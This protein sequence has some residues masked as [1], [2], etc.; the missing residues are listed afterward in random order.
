M[1][2]RRTPRRRIFKA[3]TIEF[4]DSAFLCTV[5][6]RSDTGA[7]L[8]FPSPIGI[9]EHFVLV[10]DGSRFRCRVVWRKENG[11]GIVFGPT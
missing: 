5:R 11:M 6:D 1:E 7:S 2:Q 10:T 9:P 4:G 8:E 3:G